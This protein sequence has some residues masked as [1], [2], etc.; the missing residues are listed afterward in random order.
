MVI[1]MNPVANI[2]SF[3]VKFW[4]NSTED[5][6]D[7]TWDEFFQC[8]DKDRSYFE[9]LEIVALTPNDRTQAFTIKSEAAFS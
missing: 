6:G 3:T 7:L 4:L 1:G 8:V 9:Q 5:V 2:L